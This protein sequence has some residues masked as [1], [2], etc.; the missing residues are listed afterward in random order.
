MDGRGGGPHSCA[1]GV[2]T[3][4]FKTG[5]TMQATTP[6]IQMNYAQGGYLNAPGPVMFL[7]MRKWP[8]RVQQNSTR[9]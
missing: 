2:D 5:L 7:V 3:P 8:A 4:S 6:P 9:K 1:E